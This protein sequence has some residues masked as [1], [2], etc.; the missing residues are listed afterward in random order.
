MQSVEIESL[1]RDAY[2]DFQGRDRAGF[3]SKLADDFVFS[4]PDDPHLDTAGYFERCWPNGGNHKEFLI[5]KVFVEG[6]EAFIR[7]RIT[8]PDG[9]RFRNSEFFR[10]RDGKIAQVE[11][12]YGAEE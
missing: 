7:C 6:D 4:S 2:N 12:Y 9:T 5:D 1:I 8:R 3:E 10:V 11:V